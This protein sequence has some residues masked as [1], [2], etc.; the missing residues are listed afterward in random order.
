MLFDLRSRGRRRSVKVIYTGLALLIGVGLV[1][2]GVGSVGGGSFLEGLGKGGGGGNG[3]AA[4]IAA[5]QK[6]I[7]RNPKEAAAWAVLTE[8]QLHE[9]SLGSE[10]YETETERYTAQGKEKLRQAAASWNHYLRLTS[11]PRVALAKQMANVFGFEGLNEPTG[12]IQALRIVIAANP[13]EAV[14]YSQL[15]DYSYL[16]RD[17]KQGDRAAKKALS[18]VPKIKRALMESEFE[19][20]KNEVKKAYAKAGTGSVGKGT[21]AA[22]ASAGGSAAG[23]TGTTATSTT[24]SSHSLATSTKAPSSKKK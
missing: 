6:R 5:A 11:K 21:G 14:A 20:L 16:A 8:A 4:K 3:Y 19:R 18:L 2:F 24:S 12:A 9:A 22:G 15:A 7:K 1:G 13:H 23:A 17:Y 10:N